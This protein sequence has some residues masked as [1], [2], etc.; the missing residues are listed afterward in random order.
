MDWE[1]KG[2]E[3]KD[4]YEKHRAKRSVLSALETS[5]QKQIGK[6]EDILSIIVSDLRERERQVYRKSMFYRPK[7][8]RC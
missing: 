4:R 2:G 6:A 7:R 1:K 3:F 8:N 5:T